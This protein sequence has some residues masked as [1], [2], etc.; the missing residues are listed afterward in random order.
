M[1]SSIVF[2]LLPLPYLLHSLLLCLLPSNSPLHVYNKLIP[3]YTL[4]HQ[5]AS[6]PHPRMDLLYEYHSN[7]SGDPNNVLVH[8][9]G[10]WRLTQLF[11]DLIFLPN[12]VVS[13]CYI[14][15]PYLIVT[16]V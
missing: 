6:K 12:V 2:M 4:K 3:S 14:H 13:T 16:S 7:Q 15:G 8:A 1:C 5:D 9:L 10:H 11:H